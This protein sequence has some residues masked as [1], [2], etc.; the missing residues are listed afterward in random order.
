MR[1]VIR[2]DASTWIGTG[3]AVRCATLAEQLRSRGAQI[4][5]ICRQLP[6]DLT[7]WLKAR[8][9]VVTILTVAHAPYTLSLDKCPTHASWLGVSSEQDCQ[10]TKFW[11]G[12]NGPCDWLIVDHYA[13]DFR[14]ESEMREHVQRIAVIDD[15]ADRQHD[16]DLLLDQNL[17]ANIDDRYAE[18]VTA[19]CRMLL[20]P[21][22]ALLQ[23]TYAD[24]HQNAKPR[25][26]PVKKVLVFFGGAD[27]ANITG[28]VLNAIKLLDGN[29][30]TVDIVIGTSNPLRFELMAQ[31]ATLPNVIAHT[32][33]P[34]LAPLI[35]M[36]DI[37]LGAGGTTNWERLCLGLPTFV[38]TFSENQE[39][40]TDE[41]DRRGL[42][43]WLGN[44]LDI[45]ETVL[46]NALTNMLKWDRM[47]ECSLKCLR[48]VDG[49]GASR[50]ANALLATPE[51]RL[52]LRRATP[53]DETLLLDW[54]NDPHSRRNSFSPLDIDSETHHKWFNNCLHNHDTCYIFIA[55]CSG[56]L[57]IGQVRFELK[58]DEW[59]I[60]YSLDCT[61]RGIN[62]GHKLLKI[63]ITRL[64]RLRRDGHLLANV[65]MNNKASCRVFENLDFT[66]YEHGDVTVFVRKEGTWP[67]SRPQTAL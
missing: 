52:T 17:V 9:F 16:C 59:R 37:A 4:E 56:P 53:A 55:E 29:N 64:G 21:R 6:G 46:L 18:L 62:L 12:K 27:P 20:G 38:V 57:P 5:F 14:W 28:R 44:A 30:V 3:H 35:S 63:A 19:R 58:G 50:V 32:D 49:L 61:F 11:L 10:E 25:K 67:H 39:A 23:E 47:E 1:I 8:G 66:P 24:M 26:G 34:S 60:D 31:A 42:V 51:M 40:I 36:A 65:K 2:V 15:L 13:I 41:L 43:F 7:A 33:L 45:G 54:A 22:Y 48:Q